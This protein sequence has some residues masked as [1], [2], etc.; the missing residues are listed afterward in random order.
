MHKTPDF[1]NHFY[2]HVMLFKKL[3][4]ER[5]VMV[6]VQEEDT[7]LKNPSLTNNIFQ[8]KV[9]EVIRLNHLESNRSVC[10]TL[11]K[12]SEGLIECVKKHPKECYE[13]LGRLRKLTEDTQ[14]FMG[15]GFDQITGQHQYKL[16]FKK[17]ET[18]S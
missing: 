12:A 2:Y 10:I 7:R 16:R 18:T 3:V 4:G 13:A 11:R 1:F 9:T 6:K 5:N 8:S 15:F 17:V 14:K